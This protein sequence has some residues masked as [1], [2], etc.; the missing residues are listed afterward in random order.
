MSNCRWQI[1]I[2][3]NY[4]QFIVDFNTKWMNVITDTLDELTTKNKPLD[5]IN[6]LRGMAKYCR[7]HF[8]YIRNNR[9]IESIS[10]KVKKKFDLHMD[11]DIFDDY[12]QHFPMIFTKE[13]TIQS[14]PK[15][16]VKITNFVTK[17]CQYNIS[18]TNNSV[19]FSIV[20]LSI[21]QTK[22]MYNHIVDGINLISTQKV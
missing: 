15:Q 18:T 10:E 21:E 6:T 17:P 14:K 8:P 7:Y 11:M 12:R 16:T 4:P 2:E 20:D 22:F 13:K 1:Q 5:Q 19:E 9:H 3:N